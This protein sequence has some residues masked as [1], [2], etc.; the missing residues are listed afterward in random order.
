MD[1]ED[2]SRPTHLLLD[3]TEELEHGDIGWRF[4]H[5]Q[6]HADTLQFLEDRAAR[7][8]GLLLRLVDQNHP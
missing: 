1:T 8:L 5:A 6:R 2:H 4:G 7:L 3:A